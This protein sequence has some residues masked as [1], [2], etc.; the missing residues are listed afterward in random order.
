MG[1]LLQPRRDEHSSHI[2]CRPSCWAS[3]ACEGHGAVKLQDAQRLWSELTPSISNQLKAAGTSG[4]QVPACS[5]Y[6]ARSARTKWKLRAAAPSMKAKRAVQCL[7]MSILAGL[8]S[9][10]GQ[11]LSEPQPR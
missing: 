1:A 10:I 2:Q 7:A 4:P 5:G 6:R 9:G 3:T 11:H 8:A